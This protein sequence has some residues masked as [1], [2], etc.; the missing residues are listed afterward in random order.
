MRHEPFFDDSNV[1]RG[2]LCA[3]L[4][5]RISPLGAFRVPVIKLWLALPS[6]GWMAE[7]SKAVDSRKSFLPHKM[8][9]ILLSQEARVRIALQS[10]CFFFGSTSLRF[11]QYA[12]FFLSCVKLPANL[13]CRD[14]S[15]LN[16]FPLF[17]M[18]IYIVLALPSCVLRSVKTH[19]INREIG[20]IHWRDAGRLPWF[21]VP[22][23][24]P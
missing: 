5:V 9:C 16:D 12:P 18:Y 10:L 14:L 4:G 19:T 15:L 6:N 2:S 22:W 8:G 21:E 1:L 11:A 17:T 13:C 3:C 7:W 20:V 23:K 24:A